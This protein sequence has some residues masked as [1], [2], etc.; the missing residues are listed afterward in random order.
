MVSNT[1]ENLI[2]CDIDYMLYPIGCLI[3]K[4]IF[5]SVKDLEL[6]LEVQIS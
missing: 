3:I 1:D 2:D 4:E 5:F 6:I